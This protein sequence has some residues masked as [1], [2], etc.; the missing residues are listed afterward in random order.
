LANIQDFDL[1]ELRPF[2]HN[3]LSSIINAMTLISNF[4]CTSWSLVYIMQS[5]LWCGGSPDR[6]TTE[7]FPTW[8]AYYGNL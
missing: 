4:K 3:D 2:E 7:G 5:T 6:F 8:Q 1:A